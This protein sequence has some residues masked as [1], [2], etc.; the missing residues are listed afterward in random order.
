MEIP[1][2]RV[3]VRFARSGG[4][5]GQNVN[6]VETKAEVRFVVERAD[7]IPEPARRRLAAIRRN[8][9]NEA[10]ELIV[11]SSVHRTQG[12]NLEECFAKLA[13]WIEEAGRVPK[14]RVPTKPT[15][16]SRRRALEGKRHRGRQKRERRRTDDD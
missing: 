8:A 2:D 13:A 5:G 3:E 9:I 10:G 11:T 6:K 4:P 16:S 1:R 12:R 14:R 15:R 7:W